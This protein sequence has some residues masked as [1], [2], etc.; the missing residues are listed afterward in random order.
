MYILE[1]DD[2]IELV[3][4]Y[5]LQNKDNCFEEAISLAEKELNEVLDDTREYPPFIYYLILINKDHN[6]IIYNRPRKRWMDLSKE[7]KTK[8][9]YSTIEE[10]RKLAK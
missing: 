1:L 4:H 10:L 8:E 2:L 3:Y 9:F 6:D 7:E 5:H